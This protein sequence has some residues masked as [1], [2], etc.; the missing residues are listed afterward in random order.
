MGKTP[1]CYHL[2][3]VKSAGPCSFFGARLTL[4]AAAGAQRCAGPCCAAAALRR[5]WPPASVRQLAISASSRSG[6]TATVSSLPRWILP[7]SPSMVIQSPA[8]ME[9]PASWARSRGHVDCEITAADHT[10]LAH[11][12]RDQRGMRGAGPHSGDDA[13]CDCETR[14]VGGRGVGAHQDHRI[15]G[16]REPLGAAGVEGGA[17]GGDPA[18][19]ADAGRDGAVC[20]DQRYLHQRVEIE[21]GDPLQPCLRVIS[22][23]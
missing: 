21:V 8:E 18:R 10:G 9:V 17:A 20:A 14:H 13:G 22:P 12:A 11:L 23:S 15:T 16:G 3:T 7:L 1:H 5:G 4:V 2:V 19:G 6:R